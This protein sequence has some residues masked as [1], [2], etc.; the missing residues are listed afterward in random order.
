MQSDKPSFPLPHCH[1]CNATTVYQSPSERAYPTRDVDSMPTDY[2]ALEAT[3]KIKDMVED[4]LCQDTLRSLKYDDLSYLR[5]VAEDTS[6]YGLLCD[7]G[8]YHPSS[9]EELGWLGHFIKKSSNLE[10]VE[11][12]GKDILDDIFS[13]C[14]EKSIAAFFE[15]V[16]RCNHIE[17]IN[18]I[19]T[20]LAPI[21]S[22]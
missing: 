22:K 13:N 11:M 4:E 21:L 7:H 6:T 18:F 8:D 14:S 12:T 9:S 1:S 20:N 15:D 19:R 5:I 2:Y 17:R 3:A 16:G 10:F